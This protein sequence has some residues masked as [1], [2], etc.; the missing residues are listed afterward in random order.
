MINQI[1][2]NTMVDSLS[3]YSKQACSDQK[4]PENSAPKCP[5]NNDLAYIKDVWGTDLLKW[6]YR[7][8]VDFVKKAIE[9]KRIEQNVPENLIIIDTYSLV[10]GYITVGVRYLDKILVG[11]TG[12]VSLCDLNK[13]DTYIKNILKQTFGNY[14]YKLLRVTPTN[15]N[16]N[17]TITEFVYKPVDR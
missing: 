9:A 6:G 7:Q 2:N 8:G 5:E 13:V 10:S 16:Q 4:C 12:K 1:N 17:T 14:N 3:T 15:N 11:I